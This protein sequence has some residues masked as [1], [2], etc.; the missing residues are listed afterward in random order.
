MRFPENGLT[1]DHPEYT[2]NVLAKGRISS[3]I[4]LALA[5]MHSADGP[6]QEDEQQEYD[7]ALQEKWCHPGSDTQ[8]KA[9][10]ANKWVRFG[11]DGK[12]ATGFWCHDSV[13]EDRMPSIVICFHHSNIDTKIMQV[14]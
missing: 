4:G 6:Q 10:L 3:M 13:Q 9:L 7:M 12:S 11:V 8:K 1:N 14:R 2:T 5:C